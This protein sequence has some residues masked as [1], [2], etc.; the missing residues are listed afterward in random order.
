MSLFKKIK[1]L[2]VKP[3][4]I[5]R[6]TGKELLVRSKNGS[7]IAL[8]KPLIVPEGFICFLVYAEKVCDRFVSGEHKLSIEN[9]PV[10]TRTAKLN[11]PNKKG[12]YKNSFNADI[13]FLNVEEI[14]DKSFSSVEGIYIKSDKQFLRSTCYVKGK[15]NFIL[16]DPQLFLDALLKVYG[17]INTTLAERQLDIWTGT[18][19]DRKIQ[20]NK[21]SIQKLYERDNVCFDGL[22][23]YLNKNMKDVGVEYSSVDVEQTILPKKVYKSV[24]LEYDENYQA[25][26]SKNEQLEENIAESPITQMNELSS[27][28]TP[29]VEN[30]PRKNRWYESEAYSQNINN[31]HYSGEE[32]LSKENFDNEIEDFE[33]EPTNKSPLPVQSKF[34]FFNDIPMFDN[35]ENDSVKIEKNAM[36]NS[37][38]YEEQVDKTINNQQEGQ[39]INGDVPSNLDKLVKESER[40]VNDDYFMDDN[41]SVGEIPAPSNTL[42]ELQTRVAYKKCKNCGAINPKSAVTC[43]SCNG[44]FKKIC[45]KCGT[46]IDNGDFVCPNCKSIVI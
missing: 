20:K 24:K 15:Y 36:P 38:D 33:S 34:D 28:P 11:V 2:F 27:E 1:Q 39:N 45:Q 16:K 17:L 7:K 29:L 31:L 13:Y 12:K 42:E 21:P 44:G 37:V 9:L 35:S 19:I 3:V 23:D 22:I 8:D 10:L 14:K 43:F 41:Q 18:L 25:Q 30:E 46:E 26:K 4:K 40:N 5:G 32:I 6:I